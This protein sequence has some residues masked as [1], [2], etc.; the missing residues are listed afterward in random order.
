MAIISTTNSLL[1]GLNILIAVIIGFVTKEWQIPGAIIGTVVLTGFVSTIIGDPKDIDSSDDGGSFLTAYFTSMFA[2]LPQLLIGFGFIFDIMGQ[3]YNYSGASITGLGSL[4]IN[5]ILKIIL[6]E[7]PLFQ[8][9]FVAPMDQPLSE[10][11][12]F[13]TLFKIPRTRNYCNL[14]GTSSGGL[15][16]DTMLVS[17]STLF[18]YLYQLHDTGKPIDGI[19][20][21]IGVVILFESILLSS[22][23]CLP[24]LPLGED[25]TFGRFNWRKW[26]PGALNIVITVALSAILGCFYYATKK[27]ISKIKNSSLKSSSSKSGG[28]GHDKIPVGGCNGEICPQVDDKDQFVCEAYKDGELVTSTIVG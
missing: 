14:P 23:R 15:L 27:I 25:N 21:F 22:N 20:G 6:G 12:Y 18:Y 17:L 13:K 28:I 26:G 4:L 11:G 16:P 5:R 8:R 19:G 3:S 2:Y 7:K 9:P 1:L 24:T 10:T